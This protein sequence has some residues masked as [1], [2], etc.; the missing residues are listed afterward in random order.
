[1]NTILS[2]KALVNCAKVKGDYE[3][4]EVVAPLF[5]EQFGEGSYKTV[6]DALNT[7]EKVDLRSLSEALVPRCGIDKVTDLILEIPEAKRDRRIPIAVIM[8]MFR[9][10]D[11]GLEKLSKKYI[12]LNFT[13]YVHDVIHTYYS[14]YSSDY[15]EELYQCGCMGLIKAMRGYDEEKAKYTTYSK[16]FILHEISEQ[17]NFHNNSSTVYFNNIQKKVRAA[18]EK[19]TDEGFDPTVENVALYTDMKP[20]MVQRELDVIERT[21]FQYLDDEEVKKQPGSISTSPEQIAIE[22]EKRDAIYRSISSLPSYM[23]KCIEMKYNQNLT[24]DTIAKTLG[25]TTA[26]V[27]SYHNRAIQMMRRDKDLRKHVFDHVKEAEDQMQ[28]YAQLP[29]GIRKDAQA[30]IEDV[31]MLEIFQNMKDREDKKENENDGLA[32]L[33][34]SL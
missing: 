4:N 1:M 21:K 16:R 27:K 15:W 29:E 7:E 2:V 24:N 28:Q 34:A 5:D 3:L 23:G 32:A 20:E 11:A 13:N 12:V 17:L 33:I 14:T 25:I 8:E 18:I 10:G 22:E 19:I 30:Q 26:K 31:L 6:Q 9:S